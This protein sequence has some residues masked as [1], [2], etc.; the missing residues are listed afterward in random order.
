LRI[1]AVIAALLAIA[2]VIYLENQ[3]DEKRQELTEFSP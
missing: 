1:V 2:N 3:L